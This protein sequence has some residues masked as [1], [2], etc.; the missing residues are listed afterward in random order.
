MKFRNLL[1]EPPLV[2]SRTGA[3]SSDP[4]PGV[5]LPALLL[6]WQPGPAGLLWLHSTTTAPLQQELSLP[7][8][9]AHPCVSA[10]ML[11]GFP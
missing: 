1:Q 2:H 5:S 3:V 7:P 6:P 11:H 10:L 4:E 8:T 9:L